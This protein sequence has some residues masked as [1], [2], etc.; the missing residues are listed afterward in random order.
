MGF[1]KFIYFWLRWVFVDAQGLSL[2]AVSKGYSSCGVQA[3]SCGFCCCRAQ[4]LGPG[5]SGVAAH[6]LGSC[7]PTVAVQG[8][9]CPSA[10]GILP[11]QVSNLCPLT[12]RWILIPWTPGEVLSCV[13]SGN[14]QSGV[15]TRQNMEAA[16]GNEVYRIHEPQRGR[17]SGCSRAVRRQKI[18]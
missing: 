18:G 2:V 15:V 3:A 11:D 4:A 16:Q 13:L 14:R 10:S 7:G 6:G 5:A 12:G 8:L 1:L 9:S 17:P